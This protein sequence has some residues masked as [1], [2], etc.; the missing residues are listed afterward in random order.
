M[1]PAWQSHGK[2]TKCLKNETV[3]GPASGKFINLPLFAWVAEE[4]KPWMGFSQHLKA[5]FLENV[6]HNVLESDQ[7][8][9]EFSLS[10]ER[11][12]FLF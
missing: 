12:E 10:R 3:T 6:A 9:Q 7:A 1:S 2:R 4:D 5:V 8:E 11:A